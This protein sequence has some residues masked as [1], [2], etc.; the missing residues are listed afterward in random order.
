MYIYIYIY[1][2]MYIYIYIYIYIYTTLLTREAEK[3]PGPCAY[4]VPILGGG[5]Q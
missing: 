5:L 2:Y 4:L 3:Q 1:I